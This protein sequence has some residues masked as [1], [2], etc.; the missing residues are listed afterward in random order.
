MIKRAVNILLNIGFGLIFLLLMPV[1]IA[2]TLGE[3][4]ISKAKVLRHER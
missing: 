4:L 2:I 1:A 3:Y